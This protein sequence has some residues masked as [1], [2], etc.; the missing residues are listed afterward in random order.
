MRSHLGQVNVY[1]G[2]KGHTVRSYFLIFLF[3]SGC[4]FGLG[5]P[6]DPKQYFVLN[7]VPA[8]LCKTQSQV[9]KI[10][11]VR[12]MEAGRFIDS[13]RIIFSSD[14]R[15]RG[16]YQFAFWV[17]PPPRRMSFLLES[18]LDS[19][20]LFS[21]VVRESSGIAADYEL[22]TEIIDFY[23]DTGERPGR[24]KI[25]L[26]AELVDLT[27]RQV[28]ARKIF[29]SDGKASSYNVEGAIDGFQSALEEVITGVVFWIEEEL[30]VP[31][32][33]SEIESQVELP[34]EEL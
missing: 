4:S 34:G 18:A 1:L 31:E 13:Q 27:N 29:F 14:S 25:K 8:Q 24:A 11:R 16:Y 15:T 3:L 30:K 17:D 26:Q 32:Y 21:G 12:E 6:T 2:R 5:A 7:E 10:I 19:S 20:E 33:L 23:H 9:D 28:K 22:V